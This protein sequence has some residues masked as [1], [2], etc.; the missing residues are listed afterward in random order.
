MIVVSIIGILASLAVPIYRDY[1]IRARLSESASIFSV[2]KSAT[3]EYY[4]AVGHLPDNLLE[5]ASAT[6]VSGNPTD[7]SGD[8]VWFAWVTPPG[9]VRIKMHA[10]P[11]LGEASLGEMV[12]V[13]DVGSGTLNWDV[14]GVGIPEKYLPDS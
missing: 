3:A 14:T 4:S 10:H 12:F 2:L 5:L 13:P 6:T 7:Y 8:H 11:N 1:S 9:I